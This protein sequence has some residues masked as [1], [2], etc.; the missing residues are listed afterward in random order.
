MTHW[1]T[2]AWYDW[3]GMAGMATVL[4]AY[5]LLQAGRVGGTSHRY[6]LLNALGSAGVMVS[7]VGTF[8]LSVFLLEAAWIVVSLYG[9]IRSLRQR[10]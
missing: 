10:N 1:L 9:Y 7:L 6:Q 4:L 5:F 8:N 3:V 2:L